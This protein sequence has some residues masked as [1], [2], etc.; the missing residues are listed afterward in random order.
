MFST[1]M[2]LLA[3]PAITTD[4]LTSR[5]IIAVPGFGG[6]AIDSYYF[7]VPTADADVFVGDLI[8]TAV[9]GDADYAYN[10][11]SCLHVSSQWHES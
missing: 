10:G 4:S 3:A 9:S 7:S 1:I 5:A 8:S 11:R 2:K 6:T